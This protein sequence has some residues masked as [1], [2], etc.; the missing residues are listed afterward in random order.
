MIFSWRTDFNEISFKVIQD[1]RKYEYAFKTEKSWYIKYELER[2]INKILKHNGE[3]ELDVG[4]DIPI[5]E[6][7]A[8]KEAYRREAEQKKLSMKKS[9][10][11]KRRAV[12]VDD[13]EG[14]LL[15]LDWC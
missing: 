9:K 8:I 2:S 1:K 3:T 6:L 15:D 10:K 14:D 13:N 12:A 5:T 4:K 7:R 11:T